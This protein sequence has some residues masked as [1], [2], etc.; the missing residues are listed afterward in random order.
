MP[1]Q[2]KDPY[3]RRMRTVVIAWEKVLVWPEYDRTTLSWRVR[4]RPYAIEMIESLHKAGYEIVLWS[5]AFNHEVMEKVNS[6]D[7]KG[8]TSK[9]FKEQMNLKNGVIFKNLD[10][11]NKRDLSNVILIDFDDMGP[12]MWPD[13]CIPVKNWTDDL[14]DTELK[15]VTQFLL[16]VQKYN[17]HD[18][19]TI[20]PVF[21]KDR[22]SDCFPL[23]R[24]LEAESKKAL[25]IDVKPATQPAGGASKS[26]SSWLSSSK[27]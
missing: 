20:I 13:N 25:G 22:T 16:D 3:G 6:F 14:K 15:D 23:Q 4:V 7:S 5:S 2:P 19:R 27:K 24:K 1:P 12:K 18:V 11:L 10:R 21:N 26:W 17:V 9:L 8:M